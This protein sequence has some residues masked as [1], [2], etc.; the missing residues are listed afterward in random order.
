MENINEKIQ[1]YAL[2]KSSLPGRVC[3]DLAQYTRQNVPRPHWLAGEL[4][5]SFLGFLINSCNVRHVL[6]IGTYTGY[7]ALAMAEALPEGGKVVTLDIEKRDCVQSFW[8]KS[9]HYKKIEQ[10]IGP[11]L[12]TIPSLK[13]EFDLVFIDADKLN[14]LNYLKAVLPYLSHKGIIV[15]DNVLW[16]GR[17][18]KSDVSSADQDTKAMQEFNEYVAKDQTLYGTFL[19]VRDGLFLIKKLTCLA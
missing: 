2:E 7:T 18:L 17:V 6:E 4:V 1:Q 9:F 16:S 8:E 19:P 13:G 5:A 10:I 15:A 12:E 11:A 3:Q 14:Y